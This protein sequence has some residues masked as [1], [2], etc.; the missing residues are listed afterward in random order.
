MMVWRLVLYGLLFLFL[1]LGQ[2]KETKEIGFISNRLLSLSVMF[3]MSFEKNPERTE[4]ISLLSLPLEPSSHVTKVPR[5][6]RNA[7]ANWK[8][9]DLLLL[10]AMGYISCY[11][12]SSKNRT[13]NDFT[14]PFSHGLHLMLPMLFKKPNRTQLWGSDVFRGAAHHQELYGP[15]RKPRWEFPCKLLRQNDWNFK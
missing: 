1:W 2:S 11:Q 4:A 14:F 5:K 15:E 8:W 7:N 3:P 12:C 9:N 10:S 6:N 13:W